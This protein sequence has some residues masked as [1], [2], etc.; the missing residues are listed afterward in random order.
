MFKGTLNENISLTSPPPA[1]ITKYFIDK[2]G[3]DLQEAVSNKNMNLSAG[4]KKLITILRGIAK[5]GDL[6]I[7]DEPSAYV[8]SFYTSIVKEAIGKILKDKTVIIITHD[9][10]MCELCKT[11]YVLKDSGLIKI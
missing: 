9:E 7:F 4:E 1:E 8:D 6:Y 3:K 10:G 5:D 11:R 2:Q